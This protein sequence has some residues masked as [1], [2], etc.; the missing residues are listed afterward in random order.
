MLYLNVGGQEFEVPST[1][2]MVGRGSEHDQAGWSLPEWARKGLPAEVSR[3]HCRVRA[4]NGWC[5]EVINY[6]PNGTRVVNQSADQPVVGH[7]VFFANDYLLLAGRVL[8][9][10]DGDPGPDELTMRMDNE[11]A[12]EAA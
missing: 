9:K 4:V 5:G 6:S 7:S 1:G 2:L 10:V 8:V 3:R 12:R 11:Q